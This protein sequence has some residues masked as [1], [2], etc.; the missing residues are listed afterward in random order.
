MEVNFYG[1]LYPTKFALPHLKQTQGQ[2][3]VMSSY[4]G[5]IG[6]SNRT[7][8]CASKFAVTG[9]FE[10]LRME[11]GTAIDIT[12]IC[13]VTVE[14]SF[15]EHYLLKEGDTAAKESGEGKD[16]ETRIKAG[17]SLTVDEAIDVILES[18]DKKARKVLFPTKAWFSTYFRP[19]FPDYIDKRLADLS[20][21]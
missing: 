7:A 11:M 19:F 9:F 1:Y 14:T 15:R 18:I 16:K 13:P 10:S 12:I 8:Y 20:K 4:S 2:I 17:S 3:V 6:L 21:L 5:E